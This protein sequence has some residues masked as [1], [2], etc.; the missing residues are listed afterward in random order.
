MSRGFFEEILRDITRPGRNLAYGMGKLSQK[1]MPG[2]QYIT[3]NLD[4]EEEEQLLKNPLGQAGLDFLNVLSTVVPV[5]KAASIP[6]KTA[7]W[8]AKGAGQGVGQYEQGDSMAL[9]AILGGIGGGVGAGAGAIAGKIGSSVGSIGRA[10]E[11]PMGRIS[12][13][14]GGVNLPSQAEAI[15][16][17]M[18]DT[19]SQNKDLFKKA[20]PELY[21]KYSV[22][23]L[24]GFVSQKDKVNAFEKV[25]NYAAQEARKIRTA[26]QL[27]LDPFDID[28]A[29]RNDPYFKNNPD[30]LNTLT[31]R[32][33]FTNLT[34]RGKL[35]SD[36]V[37]MSAT[38][39]DIFDF[40]KTNVD[41][42]VNWANRKSSAATADSVQ[43]LKKTR[44]IINDYIVDKIGQKSPGDAD[45]YLRFNQIYSTF[46]NAQEDGHFARIVSD[47]AKQSFG[48][49]KST[50]GIPILS[51]ILDNP[52]VR[53]G[54]GATRNFVGRK[55]SDVGDIASKI[56]TPAQGGLSSLF[57]TTARQT[58]GQFGDSDYSSMGDGTDETEMMINSYFSDDDFS[59][60]EQGGG[61]GVNQGGQ[62]GELMQIL[63]MGVISG[64]ISPQQATAFLDLMGM[65][66]QPEQKQAKM[67]E[68]QMDYSMAADALEESLNHLGGAG[69]AATSMGNLAGLFGSTTKSSAYRASLDTATAFLRKALI[70]SGQT[71]SE[72]KN[73]N[74]P[75]PTDEPAIA[76]EKIR[77]LL[78]LLRKR[79]TP[80]MVGVENNQE[81]DI[82]KTLGL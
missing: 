47:E 27:S 13:T 72:L 69:K 59:M 44:E 51:D 2:P 42:K 76:E 46:K 9:N 57:S 8:I 36:K 22:G 52:V 71:E 1:I 56:G 35:S 37:G 10:I 49:G 73:L 70:G 54:M 30:L 31:E 28:S 78:P 50:I 29:I 43:A 82:M 77:A 61:Q 40:M 66:P 19:L 75:K 74:L 33:F 65:S 15:A 80:Q 20:A 6:A 18:D 4:K 79:A 23:P 41:E 25:A 26:T 21:K 3:G 11:R 39:S 16:N 68:T 81:V 60:G 5:G 14:K 48:Q 12:A 67:T 58:Q 17:Y 24:A 38:V 64:E 53:Q 34:R 62:N 7:S 32:G 55:M 63:A 45:K